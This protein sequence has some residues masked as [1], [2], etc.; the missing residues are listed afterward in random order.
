MHFYLLHIVGGAGATMYFKQGDSACVREPWHHA[1]RVRPRHATSNAGLNVRLCARWPDWASG[2]ETATLPDRRTILVFDEPL[3]IWYYSGPARDYESRLRVG[4][5]ES[6]M[7][8][9]WHPS[10]AV[11][12]RTR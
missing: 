4:C 1:G 7:L 6:Y 8:A 2:P 3:L 10:G 11:C 5:G 9:G 12:G